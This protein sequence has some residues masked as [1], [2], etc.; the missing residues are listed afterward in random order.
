MDWKIAIGVVVFW[1]V[2]I[3]IGPGIAPY[4]EAIFLTRRCS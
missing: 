3:V 2:M 1:A 4:H